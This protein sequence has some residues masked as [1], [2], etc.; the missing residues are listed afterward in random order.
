VHTQGKKSPVLGPIAP[1]TDAPSFAKQTL[2]ANDLFLD[3]FVFKDWGLK[4]NF[5]QTFSTIQNANQSK[6]KQM[7][8]KKLVGEDGNI[9]PVLGVS[10]LK[11]VCFRVF[12]TGF[13]VRERPSTTV[14]SE[15][16]FSISCVSP[17]FN[18]FVSQLVMRVNENNCV[19]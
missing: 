6:I 5:R 19:G 7:A 4:D 13:M 14:I 10:D 15:V 8:S 2:L 17:W 18:A 1:K 16:I 11:E 9:L 12:K 3:R